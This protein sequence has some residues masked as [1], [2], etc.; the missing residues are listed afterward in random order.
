MSARQ[1]ALLAASSAAG[2]ETHTYESKKAARIGGA[3]IIRDHDPSGSTLV[4]L[5][6][7]GQ[8]IQFKRLRPPANWQSA[9]RR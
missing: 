1:F 5:T 8:A 2:A 3:L 4:A 9:T 7:Q 6:D